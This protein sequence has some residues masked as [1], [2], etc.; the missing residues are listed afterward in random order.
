MGI[1]FPDRPANFIQCF[2]ERIHQAPLQYSVL[3]YL[4]EADARGLDNVARQS[5]CADFAELEINSPCSHIHSGLF[6]RKFKKEDYIFL[7]E[8][9]VGMYERIYRFNS[10]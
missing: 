7:R 10:K 3:H 8:L 9:R 1:W 4:L 2:Q 6:G 5:E